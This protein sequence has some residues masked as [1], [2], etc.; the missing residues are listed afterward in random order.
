M[1]WIFYAAMAT[2]SLAAADVFVKIRSA[3]TFG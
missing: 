3:F 1:S 2:V